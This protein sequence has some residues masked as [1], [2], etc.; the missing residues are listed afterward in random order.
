MK[1]IGSAVGRQGLNAE[2]DQKTIQDLLNK[3]PPGDGG[4]EQKL[5]APIRR[6]VVSPSLQA[7][8]GRFQAQNVDPQFQDGRVDPGGQTLRMLNALA[9]EGPPGKPHSGY[10]P[11]RGGVIDIDQPAHLSIDVRGGLFPLKQP[12]TMGCWATTATMM[13]KL[14]NPGQIADSLPVKDQVTEFLGNR[15][16][17]RLW[18]DLFNRNEGLSPFLFRDFFGREMG[19]RLLDALLPAVGS[20]VAGGAYFWVPRLHDSRKPH[21]VNS[22]RLGWWDGSAHTSLVVGASLVEHVDNEYAPYHAPS[23]GTITTLDPGPGSIKKIS[24][25]DLDF[26]LGPPGAGAPWTPA[27]EAANRMR[28]FYWP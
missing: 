1:S 4:P 19:M 9:G 12:T 16:R 25:A 7:A 17:N 26:L 2:A 22:S 11:K 3:I 14:K 5:S 10:D 6:G 24:G 23:L 20:G 13:W 21:V 28:C 15:T 8:I 18:L 27:P